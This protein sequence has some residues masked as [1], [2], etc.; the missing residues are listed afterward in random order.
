M[1][2]LQTVGKYLSPGN[3]LAAV[4][5]AALTVGTSMF[6][7]TA[8]ALGTLGAGAA[9]G[10]G[11]ASRQQPSSDGGGKPDAIQEA[12]RDTTGVEMAMTPGARMATTS[13]IYTSPLPSN[14]NQPFTLTTAS[15]DAA[16]A[17]A[18]SALR[19]LQGRLGVNYTPVGQ[20]MGI[21]ATDETFYVPSS[22]ARTGNKLFEQIKGSAV[23]GMNVVILSTGASIAFGSGITLLAGDMRTM[24]TAAKVILGVIL[25]A[26]IIITIIGVVR[27][28]RRKDGDEKSSSSTSWDDT[29]SQFESSSNR[30]LFANDPRLFA[31]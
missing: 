24:S 30:P 14:I 28:M 12:I 29:E 6:P 10:Y 19:H 26:G 9:A 5:G 23:N 15:G 25:A 3:V 27:L 11:L 4:G 2:V 21:A 17:K 31:V 8:L 16:A 13:N 18:L 22:V 20:P 1:S 7:G